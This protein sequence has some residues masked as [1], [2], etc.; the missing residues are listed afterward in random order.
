M[1]TNYATTKK[2]IS[3]LLC[4]ALIFS[5]L[6]M[7]LSVSAA[8]NNTFADEKTLDNWEDWYPENSSRYAGS[9]F[10]DKS[11]CTANEAKTDSYLQV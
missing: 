8:E 7:T 9:V 2:L 11:V 6:P 4:F 10:V 3:L 1:K 5:Y